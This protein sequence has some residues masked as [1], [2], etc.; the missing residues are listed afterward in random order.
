MLTSKWVH[1]TCGTELERELIISDS[2][3]DYYR[4]VCPKCLIPVGLMDVVVQVID[5]FVT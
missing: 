4:T 5:E 2:D 1:K 3:R